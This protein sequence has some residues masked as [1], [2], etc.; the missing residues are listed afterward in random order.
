MGMC[1]LMSKSYIILLSTGICTYPPLMR[2]LVQCC[3]I[4]QHL[5]V[6]A[7]TVVWVTKLSEERVVR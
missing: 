2:S 6:L 4:I 3:F 5:T 1:F 7:I